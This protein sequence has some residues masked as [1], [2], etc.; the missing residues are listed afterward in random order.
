MTCNNSFSILFSSLVLDWSAVAGGHLDPRGHGG[1]VQPQAKLV[2]PHPLRL[3][4]E[5]G[6]LGRPLTKLFLIETLSVYLH[7]FTAN[8]QIIFRLQQDL[9]LD[10][11]A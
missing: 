2:H 7:F 5:L 10:N 8:I 3:G 9:I 4:T 6:K 1:L 11:W